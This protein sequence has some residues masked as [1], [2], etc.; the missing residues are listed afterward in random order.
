MGFLLIDL[1]CYSR[2]RKKSL[3]LWNL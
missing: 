1:L 3:S 2:K